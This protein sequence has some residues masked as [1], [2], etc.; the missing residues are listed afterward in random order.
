MRDFELELK[1]LN[2]N[3]EKLEKRGKELDD[4]ISHIGNKATSRYYDDDAFD[5]ALDKIVIDEI[6]QLIKKYDKTKGVYHTK[7]IDGWTTRVQSTDYES[8]E[9]FGRSR[10]EAEDR[11]VKFIQIDKAI[12]QIISIG[13][14]N[15]VELC[16]DMYKAIEMLI[17]ERDRILHNYI[18][19]E[20]PAK[21][22]NACK[23]PMA[24]K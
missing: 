6:K 24:Y 22:V 10:V 17:K 14:D 8:I 4:I 15:H 7:H 5:E 3:M 2:K 19:I 11:C 21:R 9:F 20:N 12:R 18:R 1:E 23:L 13:V 16:Y